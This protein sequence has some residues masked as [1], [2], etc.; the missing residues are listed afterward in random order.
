MV[1][2]PVWH[3]F[4]EFG[5]PRVSTVKVGGDPLVPLFTVRKMVRDNQKAVQV[6]SVK[7]SKGIQA[8]TPQSPSTKTLD[9]LCTTLPSQP[10]PIIPA[11]Q[12]LRV[13]AHQASTA[14]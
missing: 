2:A 3:G 7:D 5:I 12:Q 8:S 4:A 6:S 1:V 10:H 9:A 11:P 14:Y 13:N